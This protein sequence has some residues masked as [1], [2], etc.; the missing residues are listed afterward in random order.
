MFAHGRTPKTVWSSFGRK[1]SR[2]RKA[3]DVP[4]TT[5]MLDVGYE[6]MND[7][8]DTYWWYCARREIMVGIIERHLPAGA[9][10]IDLGCGN[11]AITALLRDRGYKTTAADISP[12][13]LEDCARRGL[14]VIDLRDRPLPERSADCVI[15]GDVLEHVPDD[16]AL[17]ADARKS[18]VP[19]GILLITVPAFEFLWSGE[20]FISRHYRR[21]RRGQLIS[22]LQAAGFNKIWASYY[23][24]LLFPVIV[25]IIL[26]KRIFRPREMYKS[27]LAPLPDS[28]NQFLYNVFRSET[29]IL[30]RVTLPI[31]ASIIA[32]ATLKDN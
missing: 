17:I 19:G 14:E 27:D 2:R 4:N 25:G 3:T 29:W 24:T 13:A 18:L 28:L 32:V 11:G 21:Y 10:I 26:M 30:K 23:N 8:G 31:G 12:I 6:I 16:V 5:E 1:R 7:I 22:A 15:L 9:R 20:D